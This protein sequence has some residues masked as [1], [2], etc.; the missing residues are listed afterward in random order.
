[1]DGSVSTLAPVFAAA[2]ATHDSWNAFLVGVAA[3]VGAGVSMGFAEALADDGKLSGRGTPYLR[4]LVCGLM[5]IAGGI[6]HT[7]PY[8]IR[9]FW[10]ATG[11]AGV[12]VVIELLAIA[13]IQWRYMQTPPLA[14]A[15]KV[16]LG[17][18]IVLALGILI[19]SS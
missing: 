17:G 9:D 1:M 6:G 16:M 10:T 12:V 11:I 4:G 7:L 5:T 8:L 18:A 19:G 2:F 15:A 3:S 14:A 13:W